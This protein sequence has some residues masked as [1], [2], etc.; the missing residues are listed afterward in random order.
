MNFNIITF[1]C[2]VNQYESNMMKE[3]MLSSGFL[4]NDDLN[5][6]DI[7]IINTCSVTNVADKKCLKMIMLISLDI[8]FSKFKLEACRVQLKQVIG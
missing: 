7:I 5:A 2:K 1:G 4:F 6:C 8:P 3:R